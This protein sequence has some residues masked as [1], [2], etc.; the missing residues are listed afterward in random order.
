MLTAI[1][2]H[3]QFRVPKRRALAREP[4]ALQLKYEPVTAERRRRSAFEL[5]QGRGIV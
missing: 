5:E 4:T 1:F 2:V 3:E